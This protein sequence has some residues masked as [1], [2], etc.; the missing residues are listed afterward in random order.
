M[1]SFQV[2]FDY[3]FASTSSIRCLDRLKPYSPIEISSSLG[4][5]G[6]SSWAS[7]TN[8]KVGLGKTYKLIIVFIYEL[9]KILYMKNVSMT[10]LF[11]FS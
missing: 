2:S 5:M 9:L 8:P 11:T 3:R 4:L 10:Y 6:F 7:L 1:E